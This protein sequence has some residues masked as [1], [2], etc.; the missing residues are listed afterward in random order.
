MCV[1]FTLKNKIQIWRKI[2]YIVLEIADKS[3]MCV[4]WLHMFKMT[5]IKKHKYKPSHF[6][7]QATV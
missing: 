6:V 3:I 7:L 1:N 5:H 2:Q 4:Y